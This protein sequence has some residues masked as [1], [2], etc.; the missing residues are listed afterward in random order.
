MKIKIKFLTY[1][2]VFIFGIVLNKIPN[3]SFVNSIILYGSGIIAL[4]FMYLHG[5]TDGVYLYD[6]DRNERKADKHD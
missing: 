1:F 5:L 3:D 2:I 4:V 6:N